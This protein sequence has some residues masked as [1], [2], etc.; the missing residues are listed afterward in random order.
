MPRVRSSIAQRETLAPPPQ[1]VDYRFSLLSGRIDD[2]T[3]DDISS[4][5]EEIRRVFVD[6]FTN[7]KADERDIYNF[8]KHWVV[9]AD[10]RDPRIEDFLFELLEIILPQTTNFRVMKYIANTP[11]VNLRFHNRLVTLSPADY[12]I[13]SL[14]QLKQRNQEFVIKDDELLSHLIVETYHQVMSYGTFI[15]FVIHVSRT[16]KEVPPMFLSAILN[17][18]LLPNFIRKDSYYERYFFRKLNPNLRDRIIERLAGRAYASYADHSISLPYVP[19]MNL[20]SVI[21]DILSENTVLSGGSLVRRI[22]GEYGPP[23]DS[24]ELSSVMCSVLESFPPCL[25]T[26]DQDY[27]L[28]TTLSADEIHTYLSKHGF[29]NLAI[30]GSMKWNIRRRS[31]DIN[32]YTGWLMRYK[33]PEPENISLD[34]ILVRNHIDP[35]RPICIRPEDFIVREFDIDIAKVWYDGSKAY[36]ASQSVLSHLKERQMTIDFHPEMTINQHKTKTTIQRL[37]KYQQRG[38]KLIVDNNLDQFQGMMKRYNRYRVMRK[39][40]P[41]DHFE[42]ILQVLK[43]EIASNKDSIVAYSKYF[44][45]TREDLARYGTPIPIVPEVERPPQI[46]LLRDMIR[47]QIAHVDMLNEFFR[48]VLG[49]SVYSFV[50]GRYFFY[51]VNLQLENLLFKGDLTRKIFELSPIYV[52]EPDFLQD[53]NYRWEYPKVPALPSCDSLFSTQRSSR[54]FET[55]LDRFKT[56]CNRLE[57]DPPCSAYFS[58]IRDIIQSLFDVLRRG[59]GPRPTTRAIRGKELRALWSMRREFLV[60]IF[61]FYI[62]YEGETGIDAGGLSKEFFLACIRQIRPLFSYIN[63]EAADPRMYISSES[64][65][66]IVDTLNSNLM[67]EGDARFTVE[68]LPE[69]YTLAGKLFMY[70]VLKKFNTEIPLSRLLLEAMVSKDISVK[71]S[72]VRTIFVMETGYGMENIYYYDDDPKVS[73]KY[74]TDQAF[75]QYFLNR[76]NPKAPYAGEFMYAFSDMANILSF[77]KVLP[78]ELYQAICGKS[79]TQGSFESYWRTQVRFRF[80]DYNDSMGRVITSGPEIDGLKAKFLSYLLDRE[81]VNPTV[82]Y[83]RE[84]EPPALWYTPEMSDEDV[85]QNYYSAAI[86]SIT[87]FN[88]L[89]EQKPITV[90]FTKHSQVTFF[91]H[92]CFSQLD[93]SSTWL[94]DAD[95]E[96]WLGVVVAG[97]FERRYQENAPAAPDIE[98]NEE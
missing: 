46:N 68:D 43:P 74:L 31:E 22:V 13:R 16:Y 23:A 39:P 47:A 63:P 38:F 36:A 56:Q 19:D 14:N 8:M 77:M 58:R 33:G 66:A 78:S 1:H 21:E 93:L 41:R 5:Q 87:G 17:H 70:A 50:G 29:V 98:S 53:G 72:L 48:E 27:D 34:V 15:D 73:E 62:V 18:P 96:L 28:Y 11:P 35:R 6:T 86:E 25:N 55:E 59:G 45:R 83:I 85:L 69:L 76:N 4:N 79:I 95:F 61:Q 64:D 9:P 67:L 42:S 37:N 57:T 20:P 7:I 82:K 88:I 49:I 26:G 3:V 65:Q 75:Q 92:T 51:G 12:E 97:F 71:Y 2:L 30:Q 32:S 60:S 91:P 89:D 90:I 80:T 84:M 24:P 40:L 81:Y 10:L 52:I 94:T 54:E 44:A